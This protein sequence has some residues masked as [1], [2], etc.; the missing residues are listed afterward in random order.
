MTSFASSNAALRFQL[1]HC[2]GKML[3]VLLATSG[4]AARSA[5]AGGFGFQRIVNSFNT[6]P[7]S[8]PAT[9]K[10]DYVGI[11]AI[12]GGGVVFGAKLLGPAI[13]GTGLYNRIDVGTTAG[14]LSNYAKAVNNPGPNPPMGTIAFFVEDPAISGSQIATRPSAYNGTNYHDQ[15]FTYTTPNVPVNLGDAWALPRSTAEVRPTQPT[16]SA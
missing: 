2:W 1:A 15:I 11:P 13:G 10:Y 14:A 7:P 3:L 8:E 9:A 5:L 6:T 16:M 12:S 4:L